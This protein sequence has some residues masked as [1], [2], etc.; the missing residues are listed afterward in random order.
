M[1]RGKKSK[2]NS[3]DK[4]RNCASIDKNNNIENDLFG[5]YIPRFEFRLS[6]VAENEIIL[7]L[8]KL[9]YVDGNCHVDKED[10][11]KQSSDVEETSSKKVLLPLS[12]STLQLNL[13]IVAL[14]NPL[15]T[16]KA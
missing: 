2:R 3:Q 10:L 13:T 14:N 7:I 5:S 15:P 9:N 8:R 16:L 12:R 6:E 4:I 1:G 11:L